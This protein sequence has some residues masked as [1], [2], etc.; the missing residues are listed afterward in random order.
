MTTNETPRPN[1]TRSEQVH[2]DLDLFLYRHV[3]GCSR[4]SA[5]AILKF[6]I[7][8]LDDALDLFIGTGEHTSVT[9]KLGLAYS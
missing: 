5:A 7:D 9:A 6:A 3:D 8:Y 4:E 1:P 2:A